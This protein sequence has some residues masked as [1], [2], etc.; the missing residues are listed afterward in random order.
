M[1]EHPRFRVVDDFLDG[2]AWTEVWTHFQFVELLP[3][4]RM[5]G[6]WKLDDGAPLGGHEIVSPGRE[7]RPADE[8]DRSPIDRVVDAILAQPELHAGLVDDGWARVSARPYVYP[9]GAALSWHSDDSERYAGAFIYYAHPRWDV[10][11][12]GE[13]LIGEPPAD[14]DEDPGET[15]ADTDEPIMAFRFE[16]EA[17][18]ERLLDMGC[19]SFV[20]PKPNRLVVLAGA[21]HMV[22]P[23]RAAAGHNVRASVSGFFLRR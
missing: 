20:A 11:W 23:V 21:P 4:S 18:S 12:G 8:P 10:H 3:V 17:Y 5:A 15:E 2:E 6:A 22:A 7:P 19:G 13:L 9:R 1:I 14:D 16:T